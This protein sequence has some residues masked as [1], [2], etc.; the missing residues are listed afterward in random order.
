MF[1]LL[2][3]YSLNGKIRYMNISTFT[4]RMVNLIV[5]PQKEWDLIENEVTTK[6]ELFYEVAIPLSLIVSLASILGG[7][8]FNRLYGYSALH[9][10]TEG[11]VNFFIFIVGIYIS[12]IVINELSTN[13]DAQKNEISAFKLVVYSYVPVFLISVITSFLP[14]LTILNILELY[15]LILFYIGISPLM[16]VSEEKKVGYTLVCILIMVGIFVTLSI[17]FGLIVSALFFSTG[18]STSI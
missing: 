3:L 5:S 9:I 1:F 14:K 7:F 18:Y 2:F 10:F 13:F 16:K 11:I 17:I 6:R 8:L 12:G 4:Q 15:S